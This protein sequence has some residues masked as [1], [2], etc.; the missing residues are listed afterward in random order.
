MEIEQIH[1]NIR[2]LCA[3]FRESGEDGV[4]GV[5]GYR[6]KLNIRPPY[7]REFVYDDKKRNAVIESVQ[8]CF[9]LNVMY[10]VDHGNDSYDMLDG[11]QRTISICKYADGQFGVPD[12]DNNLM[13]IFNLSEEERERFLDYELMI[14]TCRGGHDEQLKWF[15]IINIAGEKLYPQELLNAIYNGSWVV[16][17]KKRFSRRGCPGQSLGGKYMKGNIIR[18]DLLATAIKWSCGN[19]QIHEFMARHQHDD[20]AEELWNHFEKVILWVKKVFPVYRDDMR[21]LDWG[22]LYANHHN[23]DLDPQILENEI[24]KLYDDSDVTNTKGIYEHL[25]TKDVKHLQIRLF[26]GNMKR[27]KYE[28]QGRKCAGCQ[29]EGEFTDMHAHHIK[30]WSEGG[31]TT[32]E[33]LQMLCLKCHQKKHS[34]RL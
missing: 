32:Y 26:E 19:E 2:D 16:D 23:D 12:R 27:K 10:W 8:C 30:P 25:L 5:R 13:Y 17:A 1:I 9:P 15:Q 11:Q 21:G 22:R 20:D 31:H 28:E 6:G 7:Q 34:G 18:Q 14:Y 3:G 24:T 4:D 33:N 29:K